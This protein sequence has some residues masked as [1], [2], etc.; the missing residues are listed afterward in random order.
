MTRKKTITLALI[1]MLLTAAIIAA[2]QLY[3]VYRAYRIVSEALTEQISPAKMKEIQ[4][5]VREP[6]KLLRE[7]YYTLLVYGVD[8]GEWINDT[9]RPGSARADTIILLRV[10]LQEKSASML[11]IP[12][13][14]LVVVPG[15]KGDD[16]INHAH[17]F[18]G[19]N[20]LVATVEQLTNLP[21]DFYIQVNYKLFKEAVDAIGGVEFDVDRKITAAGLRLEPGWQLL[22]G[23]KSFALISFRSEAMGDIA[24][25][26]R[27]QRFIAAVGRKVRNSPPKSL[28]P[29]V[30]SGWKH[31]KS[32][33]GVPEAAE[34]AMELR[35]IKEEDIKK[36]MIPGWF[37]NRN[38]IS[39]WKPDL[40]ETGEIIR[41]LFMQ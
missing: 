3:N 21:I 32:D 27:Q 40:Q 6:V 1:A 41:E 14:T 38:G 20:L 33:L 8:A 11:S 18:G 4:G 36:A 2:V 19:A 22:S 25:V 5:P 12:R 31:V 7:R 10:D 9:Y 34:L 13:D 23:D 29:V 35:G 16:K 24:R 30:Y 37:H 26:R 17:A 39:Y 28:I 15:R